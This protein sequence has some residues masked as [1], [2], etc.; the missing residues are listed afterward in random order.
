MPFDDGQ[1]GTVHRTVLRGLSAYPSTVN[2]VA[3]HCASD[4]DYMDSIVLSREK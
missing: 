4:P 2:Q 1:E 3:V